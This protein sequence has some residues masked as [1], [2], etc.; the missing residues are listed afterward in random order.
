MDQQTTEKQRLA[1]EEQQAHK[2]HDLKA[3][4]MD[5]RAVDLAVAEEEAKKAVNMAQRDYNLALVSRMLL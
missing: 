2:L 3:C 5:L 1:M 4:E